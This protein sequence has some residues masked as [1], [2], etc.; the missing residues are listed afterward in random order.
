MEDEGSK[1]HEI[2]EVLS[3]TSEILLPSRSQRPVPRQ[4]LD[5]LSTCHVNILGF[6]MQLTECFHFKTS[7]AIKFPA[8]RFANRIQSRLFR[9][10][11]YPAIG[12]SVLVY[13][14]TRN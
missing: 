11:H 9:V 5:D 8:D 12:P 3:E 10:N 7:N 6:T 1:R 4:V 2:L 13:Y 14:A